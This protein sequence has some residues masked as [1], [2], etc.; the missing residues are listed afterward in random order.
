MYGAI[1]VDNSTVAHQ[2]A[3]SSPPQPNRWHLRRV[4][5]RYRAQLHTHSHSNV[6][7]EFLQRDFGKNAVEH[8]T[9]NEHA[10]KNNAN[11]WMNESI[12][13]PFQLH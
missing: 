5:L 6:H 10:S 13:I 8:E 9:S 11:E 7:W 1:S 2:I 3:L 4:N 12:C